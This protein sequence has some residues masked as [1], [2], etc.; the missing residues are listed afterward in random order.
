MSSMLKPIVELAKKVAFRHTKLGAPRYEFNVEPI[1]LATLVMELERLKD[2]DGNV[3]EIGVARGMTTRFLAQHIANQKLDK[4]LS[5]YA[6]DTFESFTNAD[7][8]YEVEH[9]GKS[10][11]DLQG[12]AYNDQII[13]QRN[14]LD[15]P[16]VKAIKADCSNYD[17]SKI[18]PIKL[19]FLD[20]DLYLPTKNSLPKI[21]DATVS[22]GVILVDDVLNN[23][24][25][26]GAYQAF[27][28]FCEE[29]SF[30]KKIIGNKC[31]FIQKI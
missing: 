21:Y 11:A 25:Y 17:Y 27:M 23:S 4:S 19:T 13:W 2:I 28:E 10:L 6:I 1:Q 26:D 7:L 18:H 5:Y 31:G 8:M 15:F 3:V 14:F 30:P 12:F 29:N 20:V 22:G 24:T 9:R 16:F